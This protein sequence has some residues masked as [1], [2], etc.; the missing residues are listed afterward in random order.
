VEIDH[1]WYSVPYQLTQQE[2]E[3]RAAAAT[4]E[5]FHEAIR[6]ASHARSYTPHHHTTENEHRPKAHQRHL[7][8][9]PSRIVEWSAKIG[10]ATAQLVEHILSSN[11]HPEQGYRSCRGIIRL[12]DKFGHARVEAG[13][14]RA[15]VLNVCTYQSLQAILENNLDSQP[16]ESAPDPQ[17]PIDH[18]NLRGPDY[19]D[20]EDAPTS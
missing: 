14:S 16:L 13:A 7:E 19:Y 4:V 3:V 1:H 20:S 9:T 17:P 18:P 8:W 2:V 15:V 12:G 5:V 10:P 6:V 11:H